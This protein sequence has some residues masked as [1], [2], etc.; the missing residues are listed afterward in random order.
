[1]LEFFSY[2]KTFD[3]GLGVC[4]RVSQCP[5]PYMMKFKEPVSL[6]LIL[7]EKRAEDLL[8]FDV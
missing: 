7:D 5:G 3:L 2:M 8:P 1:M 4:N 6:V